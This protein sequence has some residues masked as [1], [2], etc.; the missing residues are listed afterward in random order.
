[1]EEIND[2]ERKKGNHDAL[3]STPN[4]TKNEDW[5]K[6]CVVCR[7]QHWGTTPNSFGQGALGELEKALHRGLRT[8]PCGAKHKRGVKSATSPKRG[9]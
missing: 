9:S 1:V 2:R 3:E 6:D 7:V 8:S 4:I 5:R